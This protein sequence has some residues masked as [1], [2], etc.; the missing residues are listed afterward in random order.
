MKSSIGDLVDA[1]DRDQATRE[2]ERDGGLDH[3][4]ASQ[5]Y[6]D[7]ECSAEARSREFEPQHHPY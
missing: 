5:D 4:M 3:V 7:M 1:T 2:I 6:F